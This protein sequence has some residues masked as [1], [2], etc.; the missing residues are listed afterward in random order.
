MPMKIFEV[1]WRLASTYK[2]EPQD[3]HQGTKVVEAT[4]EALFYIGY[5]L[6]AKILLAHHGMIL[7]VNHGTKRVNELVLELEKETTQRFQTEIALDTKTMGTDLSKK[8]VANLKETLTS[9]K[10]R[11]EETR[12]QVSEAN[13]RADKAENVK[14]AME[15]LLLNHWLDSFGVCK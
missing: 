3:R 1:G 8:D 7:K 5:D 10:L 13:K 2:I 15:D 9:L 14:E 11:I 6:L 12:Q 4:S